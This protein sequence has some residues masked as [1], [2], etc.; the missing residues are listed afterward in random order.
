MAALNVVLIVRDYRAGRHDAAV[1]AAMI[2]AAATL[3]G[4]L[5]LLLAD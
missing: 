5:P 4:M 1:G 3:I 2:S